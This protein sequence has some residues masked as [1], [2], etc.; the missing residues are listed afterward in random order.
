MVA[1]ASDGSPQLCNKGTS[2]ERLSPQGA[3]FPPASW[4]RGGAGAPPLPL[5]AMKAIS[6][7][8]QEL[9]HEAETFVSFSPRRKREEKPAVIFSQCS[10]YAKQKPKPRLSESTAG[11]QIF[12]VQ[13][14]VPFLQIL[15]LF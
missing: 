3:A 15:F 12:Y 2:S 14:D 4:K 7:E 8:P 11:G 9:R 13:S 10:N 5:A 1:S 6:A